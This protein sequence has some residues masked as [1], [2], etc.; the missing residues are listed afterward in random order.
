MGDKG[1]IATTND[2]GQH[3]RL[4]NSETH[5]LF[6][7]VFFINSKTGWIAGQDGLLFTE[8]GGK[9]WQHQQASE[10]QLKGIYFVNKHR[11]WT[12]GDYDRIL[13]TTDGGDT[14]RRQESLIK[15]A[16][17]T[18]VSNFHTVFFSISI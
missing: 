18:T 10:F 1:L 14:W 3:W 11:G 8:N 5:A 9:T 4:Q 2:G 15:E 6:S 16:T 12:V 7:E 17:S 13:M